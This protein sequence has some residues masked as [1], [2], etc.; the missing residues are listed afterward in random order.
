MDKPEDLFCS[1]LSVA[2]GEPLIGSA[3]KTDVFFLLEYNGFWEDKA[4]E[5]SDIPNEV[6]QKLG[7]L[8]KSSPAAKVLMIKH[9]PKSRHGIIHFFV[10]TT[11][12]LDPRLYRFELD[13]YPDLLD[14]DLSAMLNGDKSYADNL[15]PGPIYLVC[16]NGRRDRCCARFGFPVYQALAE[17]VGEIAWECSHIGGHRFA[18]NFF[19]MPFGLLYGRVKLRDID[20]FITRLQSGQMVLENLRGRAAYPAPVQ[21]AEYALRQRTGELGFMAYHILEGLELQPG[22]WEAR[23]AEN[24][25]GREYSFTVQVVKSEARVFESCLLDKQTDI[26]QYVVSNNAPQ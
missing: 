14:L 23:F 20:S 8:S 4:F 15:Q 13:S 21:A 26:V 18:P 7:G 16:N 2:A 5:K 19:H 9:A 12:D 25:T 22:C 1:S 17:R 10:A 3:G 24:R 11:D 6:K